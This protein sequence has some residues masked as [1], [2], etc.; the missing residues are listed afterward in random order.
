MSSIG[1]KSGASPSARTHPAQEQTVQTAARHPAPP[2]P[3]KK[4]NRA[5]TRALESAAGLERQGSLEEAAALYGT[6]L[7]SQPDH[8]EALF[9]LGLLRYRQGRTG[10]ALQHFTVAVKINPADAVASANLAAICIASMLP[11]DALVHAG[12][13]L[14]L[15][16]DY[17]EALHTRGDALRLLQR[18]A[19][20]LLCYDKALALRPGYAEALNNRAIALR[21]LGRFEEA[22]ASCDE[23]IAL[24]PDA[25]VPRNSRAALLQDLDRHGEALAS[26][27]EALA[28][29]PDYFEA[30][31]NQ[32][33]SLRAL[34]RS[35]EAL[36][37][38][39]RALAIKPDSPE[40]LNNRGLALA[41]LNRAEEGLA[42]IA[43]AVT[44]KPGYAEAHANMAVLFCELG[45]FGEANRAI[46]QAIALE[47]RRGMFY[48]TFAECCQLVPGDPLISAM[49]E[50]AEDMA[51]LDAKEQAYLH[52]ALAKVL[53][54]GDPDRSC[55]HILAGNALKRKQMVYREAA[56]LGVLEHTRALFTRELMRSKAGQGDPSRVPV[57]IIGMPRSGSTLVEQIIASHPAAFGAGEA[58]IFDRAAVGIWGP[59]LTGQLLPGAVRSLSPEALRQIGA[60]CIARMKALAPAAERVADK[61]LENFRLAGLIHLAL[62]N[63]RFVHTRRDPLDTCF[64]CFS[65]LFADGLHYTYDLGELGRY[66]RAYEALMAYWREELPTS[67]MLEVQYEELVADIEGQARRILD[68]CGL[69]WDARC[70]EFHK[71]QRQVRTA[72]KVQVRQ[73]LYRSSVGRGR[74][75]EAQLEPLIE[76]LKGDP[77]RPLCS[78]GAGG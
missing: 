59:S 13:A 72:S 57:F 56:S 39:A 1:L 21:D 32:G 78:G 41:D 30:L 61:T 19:E 73:P 8:Y 67:V 36:V 55:Q 68:F 54:N 28:L 11:E 31:S 14:A 4:K 35:E 70:L 42:S 2:L 48:Y 51:S 49:L 37:S 75:F 50:L 77:R 12:R 18:S 24:T 38:Y 43:R 5:S 62:P 66:Y 34:K 53:A 23:A 16:P 26:C 6:I 47:P 25:A 17:P 44:L 33:T 60:S 69:D 46:R 15:K 74:L 7:A 20:A 52:F 45:R 3:R 65:K 27:G 76:A 58:C 40:I 64:S 71:A 9:R 63:A 29:S 22:L 10:D